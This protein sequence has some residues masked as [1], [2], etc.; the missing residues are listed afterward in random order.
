[1]DMTFEINGQEIT[2]VNYETIGIK[3][4]WTGDAREAELTVESVEL[5]NLGKKLVLDHIDTLGVYE[6]LPLTIKIGTLTLEYYIDLTDNPKISGEGD[7]SI[8]VSIKR[9]RAVDWFFSQANA[10]SFEAINKTNP[11]S[12]IDAPYLIVKD[13]QL[14]ILIMLGISAYTLTKALIEGI[15]DLTIAITELIAAATPNAGVPPSFNTGA[16]IGAALKVV[17]RIIY[18]AAVIVALIDITKQIIELLFPPIRNLK[19]ST[20]LELLN[21]GCQKLGYDFSSTIIENMPQLTILPV[22]LKKKTD[23]GLLSI[24]TNLFSSDNGS[25]TRGY[26]TSRDTTPTLGSLVD[27]IQQMFNAKIRIVGNTVHFERRDFWQ[28]NSGVNIRRTLNLQDSRENEWTY[29]LGETWK[30]Y[31]VQYRTDPNDLHTLDKIDKTDV[32]HSTEPNTVVNPDL[33]NIKGLADIFL[34][35]S[36]GT[37]K[38][39]LTLVEEAALPF[40]ELADEVVQ[41]FGGESDLAAKVNG[42]IGVTII[43]NQYYTVSKLIYQTGGRQPQNYLDVI[44]AKVIRDEYHTINNVKENFKRIYAAPIPF[45]TNNMEML[46]ENNYVN[47]E[48]GNPLEILKFEWINDTKTADIEYSEFSFEGFNTKTVLIDG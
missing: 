25:Y 33:V 45:S 41:F 23:E 19:A 28:Q 2:P 37:R 31:L 47:D 5:A 35:W 11:I 20:I 21:K 46:L 27:A 7:A 1:M 32:E 9:R 29:N 18:V 22:P 16:I 24:F 38:D 30:R 13:N 14:E 8:E 17:A 12:L 39:E 34:P 42:R 3:L 44:G 43:S 4:D 15:Q 10:L 36:F 6:G 40:A 26:P 48:I